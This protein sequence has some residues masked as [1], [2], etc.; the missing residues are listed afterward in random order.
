MT[1]KLWKRALALAILALI[2]ELFALWYNSPLLFPTFSETIRALRDAV[3][4]DDELLTYARET[5]FTLLLGFGAGIIGAVILGVIA[6][7]SGFGEAVVETATGLFAPLPAVSIFPLAILWFGVNIKTVVFLTGFA[8]LFPLTV[9]SHQG[10][11]SVSPT[12]VNVGRNLGLRGP[13]LF[14][15]I[16][17]P[18]ALPSV[19]TGLRNGVTNGFRALIAVEL[20]MGAA[21]GSGGLGWFI[22]MQKQN[23]EIPAVFAGIISILILAALFELFFQGLEAITI[24]RWGMLR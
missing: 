7:S 3:F 21:T 14:F 13:S 6:L 10:I 24:R 11:R 15:R 2:W 17:L 5:L 19:F 1:E 8:V 16:L 20:V 18:A 4:S 9:A 22:M 23:L 12:L